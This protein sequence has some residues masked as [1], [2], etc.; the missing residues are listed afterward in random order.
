MKYIGFVLSVL[1][2]G[3]SAGCNRKEEKAFSAVKTTQ[4]ASSGGGKINNTAYCAVRYAYTY[5]MQDS[6]S[7]NQNRIIYIRV[8]SSDLP[9][10]NDPH[11]DVIELIDKEGNSYSGVTLKG[12]IGESSKKGEYGLFWITTYKPIPANI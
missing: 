12:E 3:L 2:I 1:W 11:R 10:V 7:A 6:Q 5:T 9:T 4:V 8:K